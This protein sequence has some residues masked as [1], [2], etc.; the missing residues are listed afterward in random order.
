M[1][2]LRQRPRHVSW[3]HLKNRKEAPME[4]AVRRKGR[5]EAGLRTMEGFIN[6]G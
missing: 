2:Q 6:W 1:G 3:E 5:R 4:R